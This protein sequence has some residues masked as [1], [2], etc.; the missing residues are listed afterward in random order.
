MFDRPPHRRGP[1]SP[2]EKAAVTRDQLDRHRQAAEAAWDSGDVGRASQLDGLVCD[3]E[4]LLER[5]MAAH[6]SDLV[7][8]SVTDGRLDYQA[9]FS[10]ELGGGW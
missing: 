5:L 7:G 10:D 8:V 1:W 2:A 4:L 6:D 9:G 3:Q